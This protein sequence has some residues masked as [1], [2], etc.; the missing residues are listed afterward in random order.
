MLSKIKK[1][2][3]IKSVKPRMLSS[4]IFLVKQKLADV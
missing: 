1:P 4:L 2:T 3:Q